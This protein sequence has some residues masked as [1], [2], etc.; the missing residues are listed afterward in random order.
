MLRTVRMFNLFLIFSP[1]QI[2]I[3]GLTGNI[4][5]DDS[6]FRRNFTIDVV[7]MTF[8]SE[9]TKV[10]QWSEIDRLQSVA[11]KYNRIP[12]ESNVENRTYIVTSI[13]VSVKHRC[14]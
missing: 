8:N 10:A 13:Y 5:F 1:I 6:G 2:K 7:R 4:S 11:A 14:N 9:M 12:H 3:R